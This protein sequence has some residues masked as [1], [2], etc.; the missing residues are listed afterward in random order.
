ML[1]LEKL[2]ALLSD[3]ELQPHQQR[4]ADEASHNQH[5]RKLLFW[6]LGSGKGLGAISAAEALGKPYTAVV[7]ASLRQNLRGEINKFTDQSLP[8][9]VMSYSEV[10]LGKPIGGVDTLLADESHKIRNPKSKQTKKFM[11]AADGV[12]NLL[13]M[14]G[15]PI[16]NK[17]SELSVPISLL[18]NRQMSPAEFEGR[19][20]GSKVHK[21]SIF[22]RILGAKSTSEP[23]MQH[24][25]ELRQLL[26]GH[27][28]YYSP[29][30]SPV[31]VNHEDFPVEMGKEQTQ[32]YRAMFNQLP[33]LLRWK[34]KH[35]FPMSQDELS[36]T[37]SFLTGPRQVGL[38]TMPYLKDKN[39]ELAFQH[40]TKLQKAY[41]LLSKELED[42]RKKALVFSNF[43][44]AGLT[45]YSHQLSKNNISNAV[46]HGGLTDPQ[47]KQL[48]DDY[49]NNKIRVALLGPSGAEGLSFKG[50]QLAQ[51]LDSHWNSQRTRQQ[52]GRGVRFDSHTGLPADLANVKVQRFVSKLP[53]GLKNRMLQMVGRP[54]A[55]QPA[56]DDYLINMSTRKDT[57]NQQ[58]INLLKEIGSEH[59]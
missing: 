28:D 56:A 43:I 35:N 59:K 29:E 5:M 15:S 42:P 57:I 24:P 34:L 13:L 22:G 2:S 48:V 10:G 1:A 37:L 41:G 12:D 55:L 46:F 47:R 30:K 19:Y 50:T 7:P 23:E 40:S 14:S 52:E 21:P 8:S 6:Q 36:R 9:N 11:Q 20:V 4:L 27:I 58:F 45:P 49:N 33:M 26:K 31:G 3:V 38:S 44:D 51:I 16:I 18:T 39:P 17:P 54:A 25:E 32:L 53:P